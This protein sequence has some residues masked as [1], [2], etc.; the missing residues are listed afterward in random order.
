M[1]A[2]PPVSRRVSYDHIE[3]FAVTTPAIRMMV[4]HAYV[5]EEPLRP[6]VE[7]PKFVVEFL[8]VLAIRS[9]VHVTYTRPRRSG[10]GDG[11]HI[12][13]LID[14]ASL[15]SEGWRAEYRI[16][17]DT[18][19]V[20]YWSDM[21]ITGADELSGSSSSYNVA[22]CPWPPE[23]DETRLARKIEAAKEEALWNYRSRNR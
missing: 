10:D 2:P 3:H 9:E 15:R 16:Y 14:P 12:P 7:N 19:L 5:D 8:P 20:A 4:V 13:T 6:V 11:P 23:E 18:P 22:A 17:H 1:T 21:G